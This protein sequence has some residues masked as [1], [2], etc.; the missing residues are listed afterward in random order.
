MD[1]VQFNI[2]QQIHDDLEIATH[3]K[4]QIFNEIFDDIISNLN[5]TNNERNI[6][7]AKRIISLEKPI[8]SYG[9]LFRA[10][11][12]LIS[13]FRST[14]NFPHDDLKT[15]IFILEILFDDESLEL[16]ERSNMLDQ[17]A[18]LFPLEDYKTITTAIYL[19]NHQRGLEEIKKAYQ[20]MSK[21]SS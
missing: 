7:L 9:I 6:N 4:K 17:I 21:T 12:T 16:I 1:K 13:K 11:T 5:K 15:A 14:L 20:K 18:N 2:L 3:Q 19:E 8:G 10:K